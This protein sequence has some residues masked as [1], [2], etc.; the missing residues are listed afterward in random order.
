VKPYRHP[1]AALAALAVAASL[2]MLCLA[3]RPALAGTAAR[4]VA[5]KGMTIGFIQ[6]DLTNPFHIDQARGAT[7]AGRRYG[8]TVQNLSGH[9]SVNQQ[10]Q[11]F[12]N[13]VNQHAAAIMLLPIDV[14]AFGPALDRARRAGIP[15]LVLY[16]ASPKATMS[17]GFDEYQTGALVGRYAVGLLAKKYGKPQGQ[18]A[19]LQGIL[20]QGLNRD[21]T[22]GFV[23]EMRKHAGITV[24]SQQGT[25]WLPDKAAAVM[26]DW[27]VRYPKL[28]L[29][30]GLSDTI[31]VPAINVAARQNR[32]SPI[33]FT[34]VD[35]D[36]I[37]LTAIQQ[38]KLQCT[39][40]YAPIYAGFHFGEMA[41]NLVKGKPHPAVDNLRSFLITPANVGA[42]IK[43]ENAMSANIK[44]FNFD[45]GLDQLI[46]QY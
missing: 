2:L 32:V 5:Q 31:T 38:G 35:G 18:V 20:A 28:A 41:Y 11:E 24:V 40:V 44:T 21:R 27:L 3:P 10:I 43:M 45:Q 29:V 4:S 42:G 30:Y 8:F 39:A 23:D 9:G 33:M 26:Q 14:S 6:I 7:E 1:R 34:S 17:S 13:L 12:N 19:V 36:P 46:K 37:G 15:V 25:D 22:G 16:S